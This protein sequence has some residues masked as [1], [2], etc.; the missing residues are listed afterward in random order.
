M[1]ILLS[2]T[3]TEMIDSEKQIKELEDTKTDTKLLALDNTYMQVCSS[4][5]LIIFR[6]NI[7]CV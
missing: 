3:P 2:D 4:F 6:C 1:A 7:V 5:F